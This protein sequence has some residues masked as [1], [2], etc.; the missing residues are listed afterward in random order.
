MYPKAMKGVSDRDGSP[1]L[2]GR[3]SEVYFP[4]LVAAQ[5]AALAQRLG[6]RATIDDPLFGRASG[7][8][9]IAPRLAEI[10]SWLA[11]HD[12]AFDHFGFV[13]GSDRDVTEGSLALTVNGARV[14]VP[15]GVVAERRRER[16]VELRVYY[17]T[18]ALRKAHVPRRELLPG[19]DRTAVPPPIA[20]HLEALAR[21]DIAGVVSSFE[22]GATVRGADGETHAKLEP[23]GG[24]L[25]AYYD[26]L[27]GGEGGAE[28]RGLQ[29][30]KNARADDGRTCA[31]EYTVVRF[32]G[33]E[34]PAQAGLAVYER[35]ESGLLR[36]V[37]V[38]DELES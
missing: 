27:L 24:P 10:A 35:G 36:T 25:G 37:R 9:E 7:M 18:R 3:L 23:G 33:V 17:A 14:R 29:L 34:V 16:E 11:L 19:D 22:R 2:R 32:R 15:V 28:S 26:R 30:L 31:L 21:G 1:G 20:A 6:D 8:A 38:Y 5:T 12:A 13:T 4:A